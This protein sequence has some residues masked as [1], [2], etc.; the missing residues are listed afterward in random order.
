[1]LS[2]SVDTR[3]WLLIALMLK[4]PSQSVSLFKS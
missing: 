4:P 1:L 3:G 2:P